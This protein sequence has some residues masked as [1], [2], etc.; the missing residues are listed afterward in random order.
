MNKKALISVLLLLIL[1]VTIGL[2]YGKARQENNKFKIVTS[3][4]PTY[5]I[6]R[7]ITNGIDE[8]EVQNMV[9]LT[10]GCIHDYTLTPSDMVKIEQADV[11]IVN[12]AGM[13]GFVEDIKNNYPKL[14]I[15]D[16]STNISLTEHQLEHEYNSHIWMDPTKYIEQINNV[17]E[18]LMVIDSQHKEIYEENTKNYIKKINDLIMKMQ[19][20]LI[21]AK[22]E[23]VI[24][25]HDAFEYLA[26]YLKMNVIYTVDMNHD[27]S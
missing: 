13:E 2:I 19:T 25:F 7:N 14:P 21:S 23:K 12:G 1:I 4:Y 10:A 5:I 17:S 6:A 11:L 3:F 15:I 24:I 20:E 8:I 22:D 18:Q 27:T 26:N 9:A 16:A